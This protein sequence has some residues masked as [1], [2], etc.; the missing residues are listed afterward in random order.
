MS[1]LSKKT[2]TYPSARKSFVGHLL[3]RSTGHPAPTRA[4]IQVRRAVVAVSVLWLCECLSRLSGMCFGALDVPLC[5]I[6][7]CPSAVGAPVLS[8]VV[9]T[10]EV[11]MAG[12]AGTAS[13]PRLA[14]DP[15][16]LARASLCGFAIPPL[17]WTMARG[18]Q[19]CRSR[20]SG[21]GNQARSWPHLLG[22]TWGWSG[23]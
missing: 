16:V 5:A 12:M 1:K 9:L 7:C 17:L 10:T 3:S 18:L 2:T 21:G 23:H 19:P 14:F 20:T 4:W 13:P 11:C 6:I 15:R 8:V 22:C